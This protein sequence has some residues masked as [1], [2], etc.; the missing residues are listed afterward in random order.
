MPSLLLIVIVALSRLHYAETAPTPD[1]K[2]RR[3]SD[4]AESSS[5][6]SSGIATLLDIFRPAGVYHAD[7]P[8]DRV[9]LIQDLWAGKFDTR[10]GRFTDAN[11]VLVQLFEALR[12]DGNEWRGRE[13]KTAWPRWEGVLSC[14]FR[15]RSQKFIPLETAALS[16]SFLTYH[17]PHVPWE[18]L[19]YFTKAIMARSWTEALCD[20]AMSLNPNPLYETAAE[21]T[22]AVF[23]NFEIRVGY[24]SYATADS[25]AFRMTMTNWATAFLPALAVPAGLS[26]PGLLSSGGL[27]RSDWKF[28]DFVEGFSPVAADILANRRTRWAA[29]LAAQ[30]LSVLWTKKHYN[31]PYPQ[32]YFHWHDPMFG[33]QQS[34]YADVNFELREM[35]SHRFHM[36][37]NCVQLGGDG[38]SYMRLIHRLIPKLFLE[39]T[40]VVIP[41]LG[42]APHGKF[43]VLHGGWRLWWPL[44]MQLAA[45]VGN[46]K[47][48]KDPTVSEFNEHEHFLRIAVEALAEYVVFIS[49]TGS[50][51]RHCDAFL[52]EAERNLSFGY[53]CNFLFLF[54]FLYVEMRA[55]V[56]KND[57]ATLDRVWRENLPTARAANKTNYSQMSV[58]TVYWGGALREPLRTAFHN[59]RTLRWLD[60]HVGLDFPIEQL[61]NWIADAC[62]K[63]ITEDWVRKFIRRVPFTQTVNRSVRAAL[64]ANREDESEHLKHIAKDKAL[65]VL[66]L[67]EKI[68]DTYQAATAASDAN[69]LDL[70]LSEWG[71]NR[72]GAAGDRQRRAGAPW[73]KMERSMSD[74]EEYVREQVTK[75][76]PWHLWA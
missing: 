76:C 24:G 1:G 26:I 69:L 46:R 63:N 42:E 10:F 21:M 49:Q 75:L 11:P 73:K 39:R 6:I 37:S 65:I 61:N 56:R 28:D 41:R 62:P 16:V 58:I 22:A 15:A 48:K 32:T 55:A 52:R 17:V 35:R 20:E 50:D 70:D 33:V 25:S 9:R 2:A 45:V 53:I 43:H 12:L 51:Y 59:T 38:L 3:K 64:H 57:S 66:F 18:S 47:V 29:Y 23:D 4:A 68:G 60:T 36:N 40:P 7:N 67:K 44:L 30:S 19:M 8:E 13:K 31:S 27:F 5:S 14:M 74:F 71:G 72:D 34:S 54:G